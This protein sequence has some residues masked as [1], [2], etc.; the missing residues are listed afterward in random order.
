MKCSN[1]A[2]KCYSTI[3][4]QAEMARLM[5]FN[6][7]AMPIEANAGRYEYSHRITFH[8]GSTEIYAQ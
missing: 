2:A 5:F 8:D 1:L 4:T 3:L 7:G 6:F